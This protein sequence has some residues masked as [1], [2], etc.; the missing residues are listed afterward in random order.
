VCLTCPDSSAKSKTS[1]IGR[2]KGVGVKAAKVNLSTVSIGTIGV[3]GAAGEAGADTVLDRLGA[4]VLVVGFCESEFIGCSD[5]L[6]ALARRVLVPLEADP[7][8]LCS[9]LVAGPVSLWQR[10]DE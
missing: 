10:F 8:D 3:E 6:G 7:L 9:T 4:G 2:G 5:A 1:P